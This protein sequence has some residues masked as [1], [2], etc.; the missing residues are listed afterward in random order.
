VR[1]AGPGAV[2]PERRDGAGGLEASPET[3]LSHPGRRRAEERE[4]LREAGEVDAAED[5]QF[6][7][8]CCA[9]RHDV[10]EVACVRGLQAHP[11]GRARTRSRPGLAEVQMA[12]ALDAP[13]VDLGACQRSRGPSGGVKTM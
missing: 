9:N 6:F 12:P 4:V 13:V 5:E 11:A 7:A 10:F 2:K 1:N 8:I 3:R